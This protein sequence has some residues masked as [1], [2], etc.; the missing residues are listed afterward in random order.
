MVAEW[1]TRRP[2][3]VKDIAEEHRAQFSPEAAGWLPAA[4]QVT[5]EVTETVVKSK[6]QADWEETLD[7]AVELFTLV[8]SVK[9]KWAQLVEHSYSYTVNVTIK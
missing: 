3:D 6:L 2:P 7:N 8:E 1:D 4:E 9:K 5:G